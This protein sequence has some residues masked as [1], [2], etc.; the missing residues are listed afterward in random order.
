M[1]PDRSGYGARTVT[2]ALLAATMLAGTVLAQEPGIVV[3]SPRPELKWLHFHEID[4]A[5]ELEWRRDVDEVD[6][7]VGGEVRDVQDRFREVLELG[8]RGF[9][10][11]PNLLQLDLSGRFRMTQRLLDLDSTGTNETVD[12]FL[13]EYDFSGLF[14]A[15]QKFPVLV[16]SRRNQSDIDR[17]FGG[18]LEQTWTQTGAQLT[19]RDDRFP[20][21]IQVYTR[22]LEQN[23]SSLNQDFI[24]DQNSLEAD[25][26]VELGA[27]QSLWWDF[28]YDDVDQSGDLRA[29]Q[30]FERIEGNLTHTL[31]FGDTDQHQLRSV[32]R[33]FDLSGDIDHEQF[34][35]TERLRLRPS[36]DLLTWFDYRFE[37]LQ[38]SNVEVR[39]HRGSGNFRHTLYDSLVTSGRLG[40]IHQDLRNEDFQ[41]DEINGDLRFDYTKRVPL[42]TLFAGADF[43]GSRIW[44]DERGEPLPVLD[45]A[46]TFGPSDLIIIFQ[47]NVVASSIVI[48]DLTGT[49][50]YSLGVDYTQLVLPDRVEIRRVPGGN[51]A[52][53]ETVLIDYDIGPEPEGRTTTLGAGF[54]LRYTLD[55]G[56]LSGLSVY[57]R[58]FEQWQDRS[59][60]DFAAGLPENDFSDLIFGAEYNAWKIYLK[61]EQQ[62]RDNELSSFDSTWLEARYVE[63]LGRGS[64]LVLRAWWQEIDRDDADIRTTTTTISGTWNQQI[65]DRL[66]GRLVLLYQNIDGDA[67]FDSE[68][69]EQ[70]LDVTW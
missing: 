45:N 19:V 66:R 55:E 9:A 25:G 39:S 26:R 37:D 36:D 59:P 54:D 47:E 20:T 46:F 62:I 49:I 21:N 64:T 53:G 69:F 1:R 7:A 14:L 6:R 44:Q 18:S 16:Y 31:D 11:H 23:D 32:L 43:N 40:G 60:D 67:G 68:A 22:E 3:V 33:L 13:L 29:T 48:T 58:Y 12:E 61:A 38:R 51:I 70:Q 50:L 10:G 56:M 30:S 41:S 8:T 17:V 34:L 65:T 57:A 15:E 52:P 27:S 35:F 5:L 28:T 42:G 63:P 4:V 2:A 24:L